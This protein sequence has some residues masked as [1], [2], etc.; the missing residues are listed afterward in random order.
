MST[1]LVLRRLVSKL[2]KHRWFA[3]SREIK[4]KEHS[5]CLASAKSAGT[6]VGTN[7]EAQNLHE[8]RPEN[9]IS[10]IRY[11][12]SVSSTRSN[13]F[14][15]KKLHT[16]TASGISVPKCCKERLEQSQL[17]DHL[18]PPL[19]LLLYRLPM[20]YLALRIRTKGF[21]YPINVG[22]FNFV[23]RVVRGGLGGERV[24][25]LQVWINL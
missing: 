9:T 6:S 7:S 10:T 16:P 4:R 21:G 5:V 17:D 3:Y 14:A 19:L 13:R 22:D 23:K 8:N 15:K 11:L 24:W 20:V 12:S 18:D 25:E 2:N 1:L